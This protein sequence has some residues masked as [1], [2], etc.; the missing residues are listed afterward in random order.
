M[1]IAQNSRLFNYFCSSLYSL[2]ILR[3]K[4]NPSCNV[5]HVESKPTKESRSNC[6][7]YLISF[8]ETSYILQLLLKREGTPTEDA[9][10]GLLLSILLITWAHIHEL[11][12]KPA[13]IEYLLNTVFHL[14]STLP[15]TNGQ[16][17]TSLGIK[18]NVI[19]GYSALATGFL[20]PVGIVYGLH[21]VNPCKSTLVGYWLIPK[22]NGQLW[23]PHLARDA[24]NVA[25]NF[26]LLFVNH[27]M[28][29]LATFAGSFVAAIFLTFSVR[30]IHQFISR[31]VY[32]YLDYK[33]ES[34]VCPSGWYP[35]HPCW[36]KYF[37][38]HC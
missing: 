19:F 28:W 23:A 7:W 33:G 31:F 21:L 22:C 29:T 37:F 18:V 5:I 25:V 26:F 35:F 16:G 8:L 34:C 11:R 13:E 38:H 15:E 36:I 9:I 10:S 17:H 3:I 24:I 4:F 2:G 1:I 12:N 20:M 6:R 30:A 32:T 14:N 27:W